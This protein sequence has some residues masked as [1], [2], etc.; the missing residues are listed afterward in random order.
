M[1]RLEETVRAAK[2]IRD[3]LVAPVPLQYALARDTS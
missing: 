1:R 3:Y 2:R